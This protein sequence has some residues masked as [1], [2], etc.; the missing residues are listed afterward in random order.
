MAVAVLQN[1]HQICQG[2]VH[3]VR[4]LRHQHLQVLKLSLRIIFQ[5][6]YFH[7]ILDYHIE[8]CMSGVYSEQPFPVLGWRVKPAAKTNTPQNAKLLL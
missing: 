5:L 2:K 4:K 1:Q 6:H 3:P 8:F 7:I